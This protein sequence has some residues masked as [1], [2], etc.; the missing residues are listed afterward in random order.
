MFPTV[1]FIVSFLILLGMLIYRVDELRLYEDKDEIKK[2]FPEIK[3]LRV[4]RREIDSIIYFVGIRIFR[5]IRRIQK[6]LHRK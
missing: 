4:I 3:A 5:L 2:Q 6:K 1:T